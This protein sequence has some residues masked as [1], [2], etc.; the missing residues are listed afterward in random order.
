[1]LDRDGLKQR[2]SFVIWMQKQ[3][4]RADSSKNYSNET[5][6]A[7]ADK[8]QSGLK[9]LGIRKYTDINFFTI[10]DSNRFE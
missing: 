4:R 10:L 5:I 1:M 7:A 3:P 6:N 2:K 9:A 8:L